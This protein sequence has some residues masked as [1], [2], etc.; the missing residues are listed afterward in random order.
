M[1]PFCFLIFFL[2][3][4]IPMV[5]N[6]EDD[7]YNHFINQLVNSCLYRHNNV[8]ISSTLNQ[9]ISVVFSL[10]SKINHFNRIQLIVLQSNHHSV[11]FWNNF[12]INIIRNDFSLY[13]KKCSSTNQI[14]NL[15]YRDHQFESH[16][17]QV[18]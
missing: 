13:F 15:F 18:H 14:L 8:L 12:I 17:P 4:I 1:G 7:C 16:K 11:L 10:S 2:A 9:T 6:L 5:V 3:N